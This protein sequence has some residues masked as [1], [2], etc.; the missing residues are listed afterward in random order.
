MMNIS[1]WISKGLDWLDLLLQIVGVLLLGAVTVSVTLQVFSRYITQ[2]SIPW[3]AELAS[4][5]FVWLS[6]I[7]IALGVR[8][9]RHMLLDVWDYL[10]Y[11]RWVIV[12]IDT[13]A[14]AVVV[15]VLVLL[16]WFGAQGL[17]AAFNRSLPGL[18]I[19][20]GWVTLAVPAGSALALIFAIEAWWKSIHA[21][22][23]ED[24]LPIGTLFQPKDAIVVKGEI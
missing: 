1:K 17:G 11:R 14:A 16:I 20:Y 12:L 18:G 23:H 13:I 21:K 5:S 19:P 9:G 3:T 24:P 2:S 15:G 22:P 10:P 6:M 4:Y 8:R 7:A